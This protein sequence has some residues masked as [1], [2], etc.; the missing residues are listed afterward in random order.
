M[1]PEERDAGYLWDVLAAAREVLE[2]TR[3]LRPP[4]APGV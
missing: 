3:G 1:R 4:P 2:L